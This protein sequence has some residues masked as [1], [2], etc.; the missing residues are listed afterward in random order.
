ME[1][2]FRQ[3]ARKWGG[4]KVNKFIEDAPYGGS[5]FKREPIQRMHV[6]DMVKR[7]HTKVWTLLQKDS[8]L[9]ISAGDIVSRETI[10]NFISKRP[11]KDKA[12]TIKLK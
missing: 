1:M 11:W 7:D 10:G 9:I 12:L 8:K 4:L 5:M 6:L 2:T 3:Y